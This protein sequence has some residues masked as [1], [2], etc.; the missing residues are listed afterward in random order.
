MAFATATALL[1]P[2]ELGVFTSEPAVSIASARGEVPSMAVWFQDSWTRT[3]FAR[4]EVVFGP[5]FVPP[6][7]RYVRHKHKA[8]KRLFA[9]RLKAGRARGGVLERLWKEVDREAFH[10]LNLPSPLLQIATEALSEVPLAYDPTLRLVG[11]INTEMALDASDAIAAYEETVGQYKT[12]DFAPLKGHLAQLQIE[13]KEINRQVYKAEMAKVREPKL[14]AMVVPKPVLS[15]DARLPKV[16]AMPEANQFAAAAVPEVTT[17]ASNEPRLVEPAV[18]AKSPALL[19]TASLGPS[20]LTTEPL[21]P[22]APRTAS[23]NVRS[24]TAMARSGQS[25]GGM[26]LGELEIDDDVTEWLDSKQ[27]H[28]ELYLR[29]ARSRDPQDIL[30]LSYQYPEERFEID[31]RG[32]QGEYRLIASLFG[33]NDKTPIAQVVHPQ[34]ISAELYKKAIH[35]PIN[36]AVI[37]KMSARKVTHVGGI[38]LTATVFEGAVGDYRAPKPIP[39]AVVTLV[40]LGEHGTHLADA[41]GNVRLEKIPAHSEVLVRVSAPGYHPTSVVVPTFDGDVYTTLYLL[42]RNTQ[43]LSPKGQEPAQAV[44]FGRVFDPVRRTPMEDQSFGLTFHKNPPL[45]FGEMPDPAL[46]ATAKSGLFAFFNLAPSFRALTRLEA[47]ARSVLINLL[48]DFGYYVELGRG[49]MGKLRGKLFDP[50]HGQPA[51]AKVT[52]VGEPNFSTETISGGRFEIPRIDLPPGLITLEVEA[53]DYPKT[54]HTI[55]WNVRYQNEVRRLYMME[56]QLLKDGAASAAKVSLA[57]GKGSVVGGAEPSFFGG[58]RQC[59]TVFL[60][61][62]DG[63]VLSNEHGPF[64][65]HQAKSSNGPLCLKVEDSGFSFFN[66]PPGEYLLKWV[67]GKGFA[68]RT[69]VVRVGQ[70]RVSV[71]VN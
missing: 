66:V 35:F 21:I 65:L 57:P 56:N 19:A 2:L 28:I 3:C 55:P 49:G 41:E 22:R 25:R 70:D 29:P 20:L 18:P 33:K 59:V 12:N 23:A 16:S 37:N 1:L 61:A 63:R 54:W 50:F 10:A 36:R 64:P 9:G 26:A 40:G 8:P 67:N 53:E 44:V 42:N 46:K 4:T 47:S 5:V 45:Y 48:P 11:G 17:Q 30:F 58:I 43:Y 7:A 13:A 71:V 62:A 6:V 68:F 27:G 32:L 39:G 38:L 52:V 31:L 24:S 15:H 60:V 51:N 34:I 69:H 14:V